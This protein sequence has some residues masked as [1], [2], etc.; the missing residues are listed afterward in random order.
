MLCKSC[1]LE[2]GVKGSFRLSWYNGH[3]FLTRLDI[4]IRTPVNHF[5]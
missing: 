1:W 2:V 3:T 4:F 5:S